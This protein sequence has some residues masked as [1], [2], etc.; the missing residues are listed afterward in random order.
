MRKRYSAE[1]KARVVLDVLKEEKS[2]TQLASEYGVHPNLLHNWRRS[3][4]ERLPR[5]FSGDDDVG[6]L[7]AQHEKEVEELYQEI[8]R[9]TTQ[10]SWLKKRPPS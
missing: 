1:F 8:G 6:T 2:I 3:A 5:I 7:K 10:L 9:L 4:L